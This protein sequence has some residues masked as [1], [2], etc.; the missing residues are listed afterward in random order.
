[1]TGRSGW[2]TP[3][4]NTD[5]ECAPHPWSRDTTRPSSGAY[6]FAH[7]PNTRPSGPPSRTRNPQVMHGPGAACARGHLGVIRGGGGLELL[8]PGGAVVP[9]QHTAVALKDGRGDEPLIVWMGR[10][11]V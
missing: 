9:V 6:A 7:T 2:S 5:S 3:G 1:M 4:G 11:E 8:R 10:Q